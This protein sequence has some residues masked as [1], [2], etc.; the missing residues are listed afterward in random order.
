MAYPYAVYAVLSTLLL[1]VHPGQLL[2][3]PLSTFYK[4]LLLRP[5]TLTVHIFLCILLIYIYNMSL[6]RSCFL[7]KYYCKVT[8][9]EEV[10]VSSTFEQS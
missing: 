3:Q 2:D 1:Y 5:I 8:I 4:H 9:I 10:K 7:Q 6:L